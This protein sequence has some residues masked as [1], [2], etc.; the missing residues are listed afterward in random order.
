MAR[1]DRMV[2]LGLLM[3]ANDPERPR[4]NLSNPRGANYARAAKK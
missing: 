2:A 4:W 3:L 1:V